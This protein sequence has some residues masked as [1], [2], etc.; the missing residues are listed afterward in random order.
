[1]NIKIGS[2]IKKLRTENNITQDTLAIALG[3]T[4]QAVSRWESEAGYPDIELLP[5]LADFFSVSTDE[6]I[7]YR[8]SQR[9]QQLAETKTEMDRLAEVGTTEEQ[10]AYARKAFTL[11]PNDYEIRSNLAVCLYFSWEEEH[12]EALFNEIE[13]LL[14]SVID[15]CKD[16]DIRY[17][18]INTLILLYAEA[19][20][21][22]KARELTEHL[23]PMK[24]CREYAL[25]NGI[26]DGNNEQYRQDE[27][28]KLADALGLSIKNYVLDDE[29]PNDPSTWDKKIEMLKISNRIYQMIYGEDLLFYHT[30][31]SMNYWLISTYRIAQGKTEEALDSLEKMCCHAIAYDK[32]YLNDHGKHYSSI[33]VDK[34]VYP[35]KSKDFHEL[36][37]HTDSY[38]MLDR[39]QHTRYDSIRQE[40]RFIKVLEA[41]K[42]Y[43]K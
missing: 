38:Y 36:T 16:E 40:P 37:E 26:G 27:I 32:A 15:G 7:G 1:M 21:P 20:Q 17:D 14:K 25:S 42:E 28:D 10:I 4:P 6:L 22:D 8:L 2:I 41:L 39:L 9:E 19:K 11:F 33:L 29:L 5:A 23:T 3:V 13:E 24:Y 12:N 34:L 43:A 18:A 31:L 35:E 30:R